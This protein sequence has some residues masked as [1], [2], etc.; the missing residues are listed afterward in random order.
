VFLDVAR[1]TGRAGGGRLARET[2]KADFPPPVYRAVS[3]ARTGAMVRRYLYLM[4]GS[5]PRQV[6][7]IYWPTVQMLMWGFLQL[8]LAEA[9]G[10]SRSSPAPSSARCCS[11]TSC[12]AA[13]SAFDLVSGGD[14]GAQYRPSD[15]D[16]LA[17]AR[18]RRRA[19]DDEHDPGGHRHRPGV[20]DGA[21]LLRLQSVDELRAETI[22]AVSVTGGHLGAGSASSS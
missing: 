3:P 4:R 9:A 22:D 1:G 17:A 13:S 11:G 12:F 10:P 20:A 21:V 7:L 15:D 6:E 19:D 8:Y 18:V 5:W 14:V 16:A 2:K